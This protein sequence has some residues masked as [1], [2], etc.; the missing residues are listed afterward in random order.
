MRPPEPPHR[1]A[2]RI[3]SRAVVRIVLCAAVAAAVA[4]CKGATERRIEAD[5]DAYAEARARRPEVPETAGS[6]NLDEAGPVARPARDVAE[7]SLDLE[8]ALRLAAAASREYRAQREDAYLAALR[9]TGERRKFETQF[10]VTGN[11]GTAASED[12]G[13]ASAGAG[14]SMA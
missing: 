9:L 3:A 5:R 14:A 13:S 12:G 7:V 4:G 11:L 10:G 8:E 6:M 1:P 2:S